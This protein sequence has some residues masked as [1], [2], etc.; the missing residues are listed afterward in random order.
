MKQYAV[1]SEHLNDIQE[2]LNNIDDND[3]NYD[4]IAPGTQ[5]IECQDENEG[6]KDLHS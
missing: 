1:C 4:L 3:D 2:Q 5:N 6:T